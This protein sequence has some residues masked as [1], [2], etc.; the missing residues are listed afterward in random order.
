FVGVEINGVKND[1]EAKT[2]TFTGN[3]TDIKGLKDGT[4]TLKEQVAPDGYTVVETAF[5]FT[6]ENGV[7]VDSKAVT[8]GDVTVIESTSGTEIVVRDAAEEVVAPKITTINKTDITGENELEGAKLELLDS[9]GTVIDTWTSKTGETWTIE[10]LPEGEYTLRETVAPDGYTIATDTTFVIDENGDIDKTK[11]TAKVSEEGVILVEDDLSDITISKKVITD[12][13][14][15]TPKDEKA[16]FVLSSEDADLTGVTVDGK[17]VKSTDSKPVKSVEFTGNETEFKGL[18]DGTYTLEE[19]VAP[20]GYKVVS[21]FTFT[22][23]NGEIVK[24]SLSAITTGEVELDENGNLIVK[25][26][27]KDSIQIT[28]QIITTDDKGNTSEAAPADERVEFKLTA[29]D[30]DLTD[31]TVGEDKVTDG[32]KE[33]TFTGNNTTITGLK[34]G[35]YTLEETVAPD[36]YTVISVFT[37]TVE[38]GKVTEVNGTET[39]GEVKVDENGNITILDKISDITINKTDLGGEE[40]TSGDATYTLTAKTEGAFVGVEINGVKNDK[41][42]KTITF[43]GNKTEIK[44]LKDGTYE[45]K[46][47]V[48]PDGYTVVETAFTFTIK[49]GVIVDSKAVTNG[50]VTVIESTSGTEIV[51]RDAAEEVVAPKITTINKTDITGENELAGA[52]LELLD[53]KGTVIDTWTSEI[54]KTWTIEDLPAGTYTL[55][56]TVAPDGYTIAT[57]TTFV[58]DENGDIDKTKTTAKVSEE[59]VILVE[60]DLSDITI[61]KKVIT[62][63]KAETPKDEKATFVLSSKDADLTGVT[64]DGKEIKSTDSKP[65][66]SVEFTGN[67]TEFKGLKDGTYQLEETVAPD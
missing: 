31:V 33:V 55:R 62:D 26:A 41:E 51:V 38:D 8:N 43:T 49:N 37:F 25:D 30:G 67:E 64:V 9:K 12:G 50:D 54:G 23:E 63:G 10:D 20:D 32:S 21:T 65:V 58:I 16:T 13:K 2:I 24:D 29:V 22:I 40:I 42:A 11:T 39:N 60:D 28:K 46:E 47:Q 27:P 34:D 45:L 3:K 59:G 57:D 5:T 56:E 66:K 14:A 53:S 6:V 35:K 15:E 19:T 17:E 7:I 18:K 48:A 4:Y 52:T 1:K 36:G 61:S 44:G